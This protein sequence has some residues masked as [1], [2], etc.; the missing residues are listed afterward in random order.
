MALPGFRVRSAERDRN[1]DAN[2]LLRLSQIIADLRG[3]MDREQNGLRDRYD[4]MTTNAAF[5]QLAL[6]EGGGDANMS[7]RLGEMTE[8]MIHYGDR[9]SSLDRQIHFL[10]DLDQQITRFGQSDVPG[11][12]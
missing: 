4:K 11:K 5:S 6:E 8:T 10:N 9:L 12:R 7:S 1:S 2:R 3:E